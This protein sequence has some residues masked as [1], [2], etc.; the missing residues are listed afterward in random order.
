MLG[1]ALSA[2][3]EQE[4]AAKPGS[5]FN[6]CANGC[7]TMIVVPAGEFMMG[8]PEGEGGN[9]EHPQHKVTIARPLAVS[10]FVVNLQSGMFV[11]R[12][13]SAQKPVTAVGD[14][15]IVR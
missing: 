3:E 9:A 14:A 15:T 7:P 8:S 4:K 6:E 5:P 10:Q 13:S 11:P 2:A 12:P 1:K